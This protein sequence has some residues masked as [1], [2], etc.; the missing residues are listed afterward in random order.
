V[1]DGLYITRSVNALIKN[2]VIAKKDFANILLPEFGH[3]LTRSREEPQALGRIVKR[4]A[5][6]LGDGNVE[7][8]DIVLDRPQV[9]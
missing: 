2:P 3:D 7:P 9:V 6:A 5:K 1:H 8:G 4:C